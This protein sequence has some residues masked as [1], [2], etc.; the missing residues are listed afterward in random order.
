[1]GLHVNSNARLRHSA[2]LGI[3]VHADYQGEGIGKALLEKVLDLADNWL[4]LVRVELT[5]FVENE[6]AVKLY[7]SLGF[8]MEGTK[9]YAAIRNGKYADE[10]LMARYRHV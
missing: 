1:M 8:E 9:K 3:M 6:R 2:M 10:Y 5:V 4:M 7:K